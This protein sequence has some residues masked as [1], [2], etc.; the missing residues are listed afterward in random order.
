MAARRDDN[1]L[2]ESRLD[3]SDRTPLLVGNNRSNNS[4]ITN[5]KHNSSADRDSR[6]L[7]DDNQQHEPEREDVAPPTGITPIRGLVIALMSG[8][9]MFIQCMI[10][11]F[12]KQ[13]N[14]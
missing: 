6:T 2:V 9:L 4:D 1:L 5:R 11:R 10:F 14:A 3:P 12:S 8:L 7:H 13:I